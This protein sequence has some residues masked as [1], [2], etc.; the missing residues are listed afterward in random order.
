VKF[1]NKCKE[2]TQDRRIVLKENKSNM[3]F[4]NESE[5]EYCK[6]NLECHF[7]NKNIKH[8]DWLLKN[9][10]EKY[11]IE[12]K[13]NGISYGIEQLENTI[14]ILYLNNESYTFLIYSGKNTIPAFDT[15]KE[16]WKRR[17]KIK[18]KS[19]LEIKRT[20]CRFNL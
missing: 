1:K 2:S 5:N 18:L 6:I 7:S 14:N 15:K 20:G 4:I 17:F 13:G 11:Y 12:L 16:N 3:I 9:E 8:C 19:K 10:N